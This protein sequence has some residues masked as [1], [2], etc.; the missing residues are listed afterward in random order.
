MRSQFKTQLIVTASFFQFCSAVV[1]DKLPFSVIPYI[2]LSQTLTITTGRKLRCDGNKPSCSTCRERGETCTWDIVPRRRGP[3]RKPRGQS[4][5]STTSSSNEPLPRDSPSTSRT[6]LPTVPIVPS[7][8]TPSSHSRQQTQPPPSVHRQPTQLPGLPIPRQ[9]SQQ[10]GLP[11]PHQPVPH[12]PYPIH[13]PAPVA[14]PPNPVLPPI[15]SLGIIPGESYEDPRLPAGSRPGEG[16]P[17]WLSEVEVEYA[18]ASRAGRGTDPTRLARRSRGLP[19]GPGRY[20]T[21]S[22]GQPSRPAQGRP[23]QPSDR[24]DE[25]DEDSEDEGPEGPGRW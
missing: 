23:H 5:M 25:S 12:R 20:P 6:A 18:A 13:A 2:F 10:P 7:Q 19:P 8:T 21:Q 16:A 1:G 24:D 3:G 17:R 4:V 15:R 14:P 9:H 22:R 11:V